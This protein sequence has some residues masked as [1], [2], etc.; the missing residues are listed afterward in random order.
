MTEIFADNL[1]PS[2][3]TIYRFAGGGAR[4]TLHRL[5]LQAVVFF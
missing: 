5:L 4:A 2:L 3:L 1:W